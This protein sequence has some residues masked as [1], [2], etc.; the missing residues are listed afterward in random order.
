M[1]TEHRWPLNGQCG[2]TGSNY[3][4]STSFAPGIHYDV[5]LSNGA[6]GNG[7]DGDRYQVA[8]VR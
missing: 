6:V 4:S 3:W 8:C 7:N 2:G 1:C 5:Y